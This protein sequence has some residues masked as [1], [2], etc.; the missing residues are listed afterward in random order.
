VAAATFDIVDPCHREVAL[1][2]HEASVADVIA[3]AGVSRKTFYEHFRDKEDCF[4]AAYDASLGQFLGAYASRGRRAELAAGAA[5]RLRVR[6][7]IVEERLEHRVPG[8][9]PEGL[10][11]AEEALHRS[12]A[13]RLRP[14]EN[15]ASR[16]GELRVLHVQGSRC[17]ELAA[18]VRQRDQC[19]VDVEHVPAEHQ[20]QRL[21]QGLLARLGF[22]GEEHH[23]N[24]QGLTRFERQPG[25]RKQKVPRDRGHDADAI[26]ALTVGGNGSAMGQTRQRG[27]RL[28]QDF[29]GGLIA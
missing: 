21:L 24:A 6:R 13:E 22:A 28:G 4:L 14:E 23:A 15:C 29:M 2:V 18:A 8:V 16:L 17:Q 3:L 27:E 10:R 25:R 9:Q 19:C 1:R 12:R 7:Q 20:R 11:L 26:A 5:G